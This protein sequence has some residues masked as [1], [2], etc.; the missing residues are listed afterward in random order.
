MP[1]LNIVQNAL[2]M[3]NRG[4]VQFCYVEKPIVRTIRSTTRHIWK[5]ATRDALVLLPHMVGCSCAT[6][7][8]H[9]Y[10]IA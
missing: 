9:V 10:A 6:P 7:I 2:S 5:N 3:Q 1:N 4:L 8:G